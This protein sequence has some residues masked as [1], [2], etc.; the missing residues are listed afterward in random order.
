[1]KLEH[2]EQTMGHAIVAIE[3]DGCFNGVDRLGQLI[4]ILQDPSLYP[5]P[6]AIFGFMASALLTSSSA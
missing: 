6:A 2:G 5:W 1:L 3:G 4:T